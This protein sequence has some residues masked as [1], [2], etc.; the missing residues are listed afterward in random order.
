MSD[1]AQY[2]FAIVMLLMLL[3]FMGGGPP[4]AQPEYVCT[5]I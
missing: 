1:L 5:A 4:K 2:L 3:I